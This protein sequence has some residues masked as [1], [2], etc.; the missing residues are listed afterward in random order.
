MP[1][2]R[3]LPLNSVE[4]ALV[5]VVLTVAPLTGLFAA[6]FDV[7]EPTV[8]V[9]LAATVTLA[10]VVLGRGVTACMRTLWGETELTPRTL[11]VGGVQAVEMGAATVFLVALGAMVW[12]RVAF[13]TPVRGGTNIVLVLIVVS[14]LASAVL[15]GFV[16][17]RHLL[18]RR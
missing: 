2:L 10:A 11:L 5:A 17:G 18:V 16:G 4:A 3:R 9:A 12:L 6:G 8:F 7:L 14:F 15:V 1:A 13:G